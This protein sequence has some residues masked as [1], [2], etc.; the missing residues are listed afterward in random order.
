V[1][2]VPRDLAVL[3]DLGIRDRMADP[4]DQAYHTHAFVLHRLGGGTTSCVDSVFRRNIELEAMRL[5]GQGKEAVC[6]GAC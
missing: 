2:F 4:G 5:F 3:I 6:T 1:V